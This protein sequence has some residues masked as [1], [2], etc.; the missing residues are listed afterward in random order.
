MYIYIYTLLY[1]HSLKKC[2]IV[3]GGQFSVEG[4]SKLVTMKIAAYGVRFI[5]TCI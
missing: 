3:S 5:I 2:R 4:K 1:L